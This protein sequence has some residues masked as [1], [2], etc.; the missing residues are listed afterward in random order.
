MTVQIPFVGFSTF[1][2]SRERVR[3]PEALLL[4]DAMKM[5]GGTVCSLSLRCAGR[6]AI[7]A[8]AAASRFSEDD[9]VEIADYDPV[10]H[11][12]LAIGL[13]EPSLDTP[14]HWLSYRTDPA[15]GAA[16][17]V[18]FEGKK[19]GVGKRHPFGTFDEAMEVVK[20]AKEKGAPAGVEGRGYLLRARTLEEL[21]KVLKGNVTGVN[22]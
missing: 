14:L 16:A 7:G 5:L 10:R 6:F 20:L 3:L 17:F 21:V 8:Q 11:S 15:S 22:S 1:F 19:E 4:V 12:V 2:V 13:K 9:V 18:K